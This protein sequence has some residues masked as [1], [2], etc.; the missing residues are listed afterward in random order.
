MNSKTKIGIATGTLAL[1]AWFSSGADSKPNH[2]A[3]AGVQ[4]LMDDAFDAGFKL[5]WACRN[6][7]G[8]RADAD[9]L[10]KAHRSNDIVATIKWFEEAKK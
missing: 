5:G 10:M 8:T 2:E 6:H 9:F 1:V 7:G 4:A 3:P